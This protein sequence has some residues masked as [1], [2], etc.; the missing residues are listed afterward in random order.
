MIPGGSA[1]RARSTSVAK[2]TGS[3]GRTPRRPAK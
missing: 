1:A 3:F 2:S